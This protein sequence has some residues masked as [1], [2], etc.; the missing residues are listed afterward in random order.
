MYCTEHAEVVRSQTVQKRCRC[1]FV[2]VTVCHPRRPGL[3][4]DATLLARASCYGLRPVRARCGMRRRNALRSG[5]RRLHQSSSMMVGDSSMLMSAKKRVAARRA[6]ESSSESESES[7]SEGE[8]HPSSAAAHSARQGLRATSSPERLLEAGR[9]IFSVTFGDVGGGSEE[10]AE[11]ALESAGQRRLREELGSA[12]TAEARATALLRGAREEARVEAARLR[13][14]LEAQRAAAA[15]LEAQLREARA[16]SQARLRDLVELEEEGRGFD[17]AFAEQKS[18]VASLR[19]ELERAAQRAEGERR[20]A[21]EREAV[22]AQ[23][24]QCARTA[25]QGP[26][27]RR[28]PCRRR[29]RRQ[30]RHRRPVSPEGPE[31]AGLTCG[32]VLVRAGLTRLPA[33]CDG[34]SGRRSLP[35]RRRS[36]RRRS[37]PRCARSC[38]GGWTRPMRRRCWSERR[39][40]R[41]RSGA[42]PAS[43]PPRCALFYK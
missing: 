17:K 6:L 24:P 28:D 32:L 39:R 23:G 12:R 33:V 42:S 5:R 11:Q 43:S 37:R 7:G 18:E 8:G 14:E 20:V 26:A 38:G 34:L 15:E 29:R 9:D 3:T 30:R 10:A 13:S 25:S 2:C 41:P 16:E 1:D 27:G 35:R 31:G 4:V 19:E 40:R 36:T 21:R 22:R